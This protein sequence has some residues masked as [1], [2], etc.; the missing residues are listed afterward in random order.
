VKRKVHE[1]GSK[2]LEVLASSITG[3]RI[4]ISAKQSSRAGQFV[5]NFRFIYV[6]KVPRKDKLVSHFVERCLRDVIESK[7]LNSGTPTKSLCNVRRHGNSGAP[8]LRPQTEYFMIRKSR[9]APV[10]VKH[11]LV[12]LLPDFQIFK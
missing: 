4:N 5:E 6:F 1:A 3:D 11:E 8:K 9:G 12:R 7:L 2:E 10:D